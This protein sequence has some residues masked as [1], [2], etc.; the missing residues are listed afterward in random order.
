MWSKPNSF[1]VLFFGPHRQL[2][3]LT[4]SFSPGC[5]NKMTPACTVI[6]STLSFCFCRIRCLH[7]LGHMT[8]LVCGGSFLMR[9]SCLTHRLYSDR[10][11]MSF[12]N[13]G[14]SLDF[15]VTW[16]GDC[17]SFPSTYMNHRLRAVC[18]SNVTSLHHFLLLRNRMVLKSPILLS[19]P[20]ILNEGE[21]KYGGNLFGPVSS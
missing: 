21:E 19:S 20:S 15:L 8:V 6:A 16:C 1:S 13:C 4:L 18:V 7:C 3:S 2:P 11:S 12:T 10:L 17:R 9:F 5:N 14:H